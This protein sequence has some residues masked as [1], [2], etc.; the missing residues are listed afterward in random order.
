MTFTNGSL[1]CFR[2][3]PR[4]YELSHVLKL[5]PAEVS[6][7]IAVG[8]AFHTALETGECPPM[9]SAYDMAIVAAMV[10]RYREVW[11]VLDII[12][13]EVP[14]WIDVNGIAYGGVI[15]AIIRL[16]DG[17]LAVAEYKTTSEDFSAGSDYW[18]RLRLDSQITGYVVA[19]RA[20]GYAVETVLYDVT[21]R[22]AIRPLKAS[23]E[24]KLKKDGTPYAN[25]RLTDETPE[26]YAARCVEALTPEC[27][28]RH[29][30]A[31]LDD[32]LELWAKD[33]AL[34]SEA[35]AAAR[36]YRNTD[37]CD[38]RFTC[39]YLSIC[40]LSEPGVPTGFIRVDDIHPEVSAA[41]GQACKGV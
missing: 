37:A 31:R 27:F 36:W 4:R 35:V 28:A 20:L 29:E 17:R 2:A 25:C 40:H 24:I 6:Y 39:D 7:P 33:L 41:Q 10:A 11:P 34:Q 38:A 9:D 14:F 8:R 12:A 18:V 5:R 16:A 3:C 32:D 15:D 22:P 23:K 13:R 1:T 26:E 21:R 19:A 30:I